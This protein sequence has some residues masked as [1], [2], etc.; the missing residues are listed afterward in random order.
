MND[1]L[2]TF[3][4]TRFADFEAFMKANNRKEVMRDL[5]GAPA[6]MRYQV[7]RV[8]TREAFEP[9][10]VGDRLS[11]EVSCGTGNGVYKFM[12]LGW[13]ATPE[14]AVEMMEGSK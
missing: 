6:S 1:T 13:G 3:E 2:P 8:V 9:V 12:L 5:V 11:H 4:Q 14:Q 10:Y 7:G